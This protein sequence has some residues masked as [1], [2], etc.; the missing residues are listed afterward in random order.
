MKIFQ[1]R[2][3][4]AISSLATCSFSTYLLC[5]L[6]VSPSMNQANTIYW[7]WILFGS[8]ILDNIII[9]IPLLTYP[10][11]HCYSRCKTYQARKSICIHYAAIVRVL[12]PT[13]S[14]RQQIQ[15]NDLSHPFTSY[16]KNDLKL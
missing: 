1:S 16:T 14:R 10:S 6:R 9:H 7:N 15:S 11:S 12:P 2:T 5:I 4:G 3:Y 8:F 13:H